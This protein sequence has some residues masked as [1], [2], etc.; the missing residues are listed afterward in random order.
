VI[1]TFQDGTCHVELTKG[2]VDELA[3]LGNNELTPKNRSLGATFWYLA[4]LVEQ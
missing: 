1:Q 2:D 3:R 4:K